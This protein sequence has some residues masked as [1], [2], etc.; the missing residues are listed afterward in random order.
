VSATKSKKLKISR[1]F[2]LITLLGV[3]ILSALCVPNNEYLVL[4]S[5]TRLAGVTL[6]LLLFSV[7]YYFS[8]TNE[9][10]FY[11]VDIWWFILIFYTGISSLW[12]TN[13]GYA[14][15]GTMVTIVL[16]ICYKAFETIDWEPIKVQYITYYAVLFCL[17][18][19]MCV[20][21]Y[22]VRDNIA[23]GFA[24]T[25]KIDLSTIEI[26]HKNISVLG[27]LI[28]VLTPYII[29]SDNPISRKIAPFI[30]TSGIIILYASASIQLT[31]LLT[32]LSVIYILYIMKY[33]QG[34]KYLVLFG[35]ICIVSVALYVSNRKSPINGNESLL[36][37]EISNQQERLKLLEA[38]FNLFQESPLVGIGKN[39]W[40]VDYKKYYQSTESAGQDTNYR[41]AQNSFMQ[42]LSE[43][44]LIGLLIYAY[45]FIIPCLRLINNRAILSKLEVASLVSVFLYFL[46]SLVYGSI[47]NYYGNF[48]GLSLIAVMSLGILSFKSNAH[49]DIGKIK[50]KSA[51]QLPN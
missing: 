13:S 36:T 11:T 25:A 2:S 12:A 37:Q 15:E 35:F 42:L 31:I 44:G 39:N 26:F 10:K 41:H 14:I 4:N 28:V 43:Q 33:N 9:V 20:T 6:L 16:Y 21:L 34:W 17:L 29:F 5:D 30:L 50:V 3:F 48:Q 51:K 24:S 1:A 47:Y 40:E 22:A 38:S 8:E 18:V 49:F 27:S 19:A 7:F 32:L 23:S 45:I 46:S